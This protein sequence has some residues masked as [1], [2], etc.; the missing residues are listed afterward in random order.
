MKA[1][2]I[3]V[4]TFAMFASPAFAATFSATSDTLFQGRMDNSGVPYVAGWETLWGAGGTPELQGEAYGN[5]SFDRGFDQPV[6]WELFV[7]AA[8]GEN[9]KIDWTL[10]R[11]R[12]NLP[13]VGWMMD[14]GRI[15]WSPS[16]TLRLEAWAG[17][18]EHV[19]LGSY[20]DGVPVA[21]LNA[22]ATAGPVTA[23]FG[24]LGEA[25]PT[26][27]VH[28]DLQVTYARPQSKLAPYANLVLDAGFDSAGAAVLEKGRLSLGLR[29]I[30]GTR[31]SL[32]GEHRQALN[33]TSPIAPLILATI[34]P[35][36]YDELGG[37][38][39][40]SAAD[41]SKLWIEGSVQSYS[42][43]PNDEPYR[44]AGFAATTTW[45]PQ[46]GSE[47]WCL[48]P[49]WRA[50]SGP[51][52]AYHAFVADIAVPT[53]SVVGTHVIATVA[54]FH[55]A[56]EEWDTLL[57]LGATATVKPTRRL[58][59]S[60]GGEVAHDALHPINPRLWLSLRVEML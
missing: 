50:A 31:V 7:L 59:G 39:G 36:G 26:P 32:W 33:T 58:T 56:H 14:G 18:A 47:S 19:A 25:G 27:A 5:L 45:S 22:T 3:A 10:G 48:S 12:L 44:E 43:D 17:Q 40:W 42:P 1:A 4:L 13:S 54:P 53:P 15:A 8:D 21:R 2:P 46:C 35:L 37:G 55:L 30:P 57:A 6:A 49:S 11:Q 9:G 29:P 41:T 28:P 24:V 20:L 34:A 16:K 51:A 23:A 38:F 60:V 52:G